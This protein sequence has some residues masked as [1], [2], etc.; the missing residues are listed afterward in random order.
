MSQTNLSAIR[1][2]IRRLTRSPSESQITNSQLDEYINTFVLY[3][4]PEQLRLFNLKTTFTFY[5]QPFID[6]YDTTTS[7]PND[8]LYNFKNKY[9]TVEPPL[10]IA[11]YLSLLSLSREQFFG[12]YPFVNDILSIGTAGD[13]VTQSFSGVLSNTP[14]LQRSVLFS[15]VDVNGNGLSLVDIP[16]SSTTGNLVVPNNTASLG[17]INYV[18]GA[19]SFTFPNP[20]AQGAAIN[21]QTVPYV[22]SIPQAALFY[23]GKFTL[24]PVPDQPYKI[25]LDAYIR[26]TELLDSNQSPELQEWW[27]YIAYGAA[28]KIFEDRMDLDS[29]Q[30]IMSEFKSQ[31]RLILRR[32]IVQQT[33]QRTA[34][35]YSDQTAL[36]YG[37]G[38]WGWGGGGLF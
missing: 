4:F 16:I 13:G 19:Y 1:T 9:I 12:I 33:S 29:V 22:A 38:G 27:Q 34:T 24:R 18:T 21:S 36:G 35:I 5:A 31:E 26:P 6:V 23:D 32:T 2:K 7:D 10:Y 20:P 28:K 30:L 14:I 25:T 37:Q 8:P 3:D 15:S 11:G 17:T